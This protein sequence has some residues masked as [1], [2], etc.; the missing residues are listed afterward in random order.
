MSADVSR[1]QRT[2][3]P[4]FTQSVQELTEEYQRSHPGET[5]ASESGSGEDQA[6]PRETPDSDVKGRENCQ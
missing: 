2:A 5:G 3:N 1:R 6:R 4:S